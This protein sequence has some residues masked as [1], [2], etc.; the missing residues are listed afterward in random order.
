MLFNSPEFLVFFPLAVGG[1]FLCPAGARWLWLLAASYLF[2]MAWEPG[3]ALLLATSTAVDYAAG[4]AMARHADRRARRPW[5][6]LSLL[7]NLG[8][9][10]FFKYHGFFADTLR[11]L[12]DAAGLDLRLPGGGFLLPVGISF[13]TFQT[14]A[15][16]IEVYRGNI[17]PERHLGRFALFVAFWPQLVAGPIERP[18]TLLPQ[19]A[20]RHAF[21]YTRVVFGLQRMAWGFFKKLVIAD[22]IALVVDPVYADPA[23]HTGPVLALA[24]V[25]FA[26]Q[27][28]CDFS[29]YCDIAIG[30]AQVMGFRLM[31]NFNRPFAARNIEEFWRRWHISLSTWFRDYLYLPLGGNRVAAPLHVRN[32]LVVFVISGLWHG[33]NWTFVAWGALHAVYLIAGRATRPG[34]ARAAQA[35]GLPRVPRVH[36]ALQVAATFG[37]FAFSM[38]LFRAATLADAAAVFA[39]L[40][41]GWTQPVAPALAHAGATPLALLG[42][43][44]A[45]ILLE[46]VQRLQADAPLRPRIARLPMP[47]RWT[48]YAGLLLATL[49][50]GVFR[51]NAFIYF[52]F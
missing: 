2:Y 48:L 24:T 11:P 26:Y 27:L 20:Q 50:F 35:L 44:A 7:V 16:S 22:R 19:F 41:R 25:L 36:A 40:P 1:Y 47:L 8:L 31:E 28:Y 18:Q 12:A 23:A 17:P 34:R 29:A 38:I 15:Y 45:L 33:A 51:E 46:A 49:A 21:D 14:L 9:L 43:A 39:G 3:Y 13:Y 5:L 32:L 30:A 10:G 4:R 6:A 52:Q 42:I 37:L